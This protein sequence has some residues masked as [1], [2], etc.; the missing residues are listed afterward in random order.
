MLHLLLAFLFFGTPGLLAVM[1]FGGGHHHHHH[2]HD[3]DC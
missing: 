1:L 3:C 2:R